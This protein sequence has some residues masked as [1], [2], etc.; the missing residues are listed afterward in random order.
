M[1]LVPVTVLPMSVNWNATASGDHAVS[2]VLATTADTVYR[3]SSTQVTVCCPDPQVFQISLYTAGI[4][5][6]ATRSEVVGPTPRRFN[7]RAPRYLDY[8]SA[9]YWR[10]VLTGPGRVAGIA[11][12]T[13]KS[14]GIDT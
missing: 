6:L 10:Y 12:F 7:V 13:V 5:R 14:G 3:P 11:G 2:P 1:T 8:Q 4:E 9:A